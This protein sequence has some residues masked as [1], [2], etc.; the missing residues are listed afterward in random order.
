MYEINLMRITMSFP[1][2]PRGDLQPEFISG[3]KNAGILK[4]A[5]T[6]SA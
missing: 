2:K 6:S 4:D 5:E 3:S 1:P